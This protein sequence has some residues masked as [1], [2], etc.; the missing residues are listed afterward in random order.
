MNELLILNKYRDRLRSLRRALE[1]LEE[2]KT[3]IRSCL[4]GTGG[5]TQSGR[6]GAYFEDVVAKYE[7]VY[8]E[9]VDT[10]N[11]YINAKNQIYRKIE[12]LE[13]KRYRNI[14]F[15]RY[16]CGYTVTATMKEC[17]YNGE[18]GFYRLLKSAKQAY[19]RMNEDDE[20]T[21]KP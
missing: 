20:N 2:R 3:S 17:G 11:D 1:E 15:Y 13:D 9:Y 12:S 4:S 16:V 6:P 7:E 19:E 14:L 10:I 18:R 8:S 5:R 21:G